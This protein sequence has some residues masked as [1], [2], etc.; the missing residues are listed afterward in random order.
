M[1]VARNLEIYRHAE[2]DESA[3]SRGRTPK[4]VSEISWT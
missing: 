2:R 3:G 4:L 1:S